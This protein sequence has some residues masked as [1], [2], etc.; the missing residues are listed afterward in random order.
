MT[1]TP[2]IDDRRAPTDQPIAD[3]LA[4]RWSPRSYEAGHEISD[5]EVATLL[6]AARWAPSA[7]NRQPRRF[8]VGRRG[9]DVHA[10][11]ASTINER[12]QVWAPRASLLILG[13]VERHA[14]DGEPQRFS[15]YDLGQAI[16]HLS[17]QA[18]AL[19]LHVRQMGGFDAQQ[20]AA[21]FGIEEPL[22]PFVTV[23]V[24]RAT[25]ADELEESFVERDT[26][27]RVRLPLDDLVLERA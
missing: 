12:N 6:E 19:G 22:E 20:A 16:A 11:L 24:G 23:A 13:I 27:P 18:Q 5:N 2:E 1:T 9:T 10:R 14:T 21:E 15:E 8:I 3:L 25:P 17:V 26:A 4:R 7:Q